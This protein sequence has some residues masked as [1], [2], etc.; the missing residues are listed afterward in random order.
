MNRLK[1][2]Q[3]FAICVLTWG[4]TWHAI[5]YQ[6]THTTPEFGVAIRF[7]LAGATVLLLCLWRGESL[8]C[9]ASDH[10]ALAVQGAFMYGLSYFCVYRAEL[11]LPSGVVAIGY[12]ASPLI[13]GLG[14]LLLFGTALSGRFIAGG[15]LGL[16]GVTLLFW[17]E[18]GKATADAGGVGGRDKDALLGAALTLG[19]VLLSAA[20]SLTASRNRTRGLAFW[21][22]LGWG[23]FYGGAISFVVVLAL[24]QPIGLP[25]A[26]TWWLS[27]L[28]LA[29]AGSALTFA[30]FLTLMDRLGPGPA[31]AVG[32]MTPLLALCVSVALEGFQPSGLTFAGAALAVLGNVLMLRR[33][34]TLRRPP[35]SEVPPRAT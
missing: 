7:A 18:I 28:Y 1:N 11:H 6:L 30:C 3:L 23:L 33:A 8:R 10:A 32:V 15:I 29:W 4:T 27:L 26:P 14:A 9:H 12:S 19:A 35:T 5:T 25:T 22:A 17:P 21:P 20:G 13:S 16:A 24:G 31:G 34:T 2:W